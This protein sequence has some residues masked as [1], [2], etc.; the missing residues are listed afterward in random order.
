MPSNSTNCAAGRHLQHRVDGTK[1]CKNCGI[2]LCS[3][4][5]FNLRG[6]MRPAG[7][8]G[9]H[10]NAWSVVTGDHKTWDD[11]DG[12]YVDTHAQWVALVNLLGRGQEYR[13]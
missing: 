12:T 1:C 6:C 7:H 8:S 2:Q 5:T 10:T 13:A 9:P 3:H 4:H 11:A